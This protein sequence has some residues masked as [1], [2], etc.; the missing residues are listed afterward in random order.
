MNTL[1]VVHINCLFYLELVIITVIISDRWY[2]G[3]R[4]KKIIDASMDGSLYY[5]LL[6]YIYVIEYCNCMVE[7]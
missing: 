7:I 6:Y 4:K 1:V 2:C 3:C 5:I